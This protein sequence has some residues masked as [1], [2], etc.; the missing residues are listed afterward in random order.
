MQNEDII[1]LRYML[2][3][4]NEAVEFVSCKTRKDLDKNRMLTL[5]VIKSIEII[6]EAASKISETVTNDTADIIP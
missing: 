4:A 6:G 2:D 1:R 3:T 5:S